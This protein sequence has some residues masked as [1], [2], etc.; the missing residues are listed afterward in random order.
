MVSRGGQNLNECFRVLREPVTALLDGIGGW[1][2]RMLPCL[3]RVEHWRARGTS[4]QRADKR[5]FRER[6]YKQRSLS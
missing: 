6:V 4:E 2:L 3:L 5:P 1:L